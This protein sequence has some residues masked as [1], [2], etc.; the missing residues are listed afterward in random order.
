MGEIISNID[1][2]G[3]LSLIFDKANKAHTALRSDRVAVVKK[4][5]G[6]VDGNKI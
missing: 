4:N 3:R 5:P 1:R 6:F 2:C